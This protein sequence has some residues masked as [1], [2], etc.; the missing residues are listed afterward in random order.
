MSCLLFVLGE[1]LDGGV[2]RAVSRSVYSFL[3]YVAQSMMMPFTKWETP[4]EK[5]LEARAGKRELSFPFNAT[6][7]LY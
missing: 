1:G 6:L 2:G 3:T 7:N 4:E 5:Q